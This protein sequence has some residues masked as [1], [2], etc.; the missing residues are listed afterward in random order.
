[1][2]EKESIETENDDVHPF[3]LKHQSLVRP[4]LR[5]ITLGNWMF[6]A[7]ADL[8]RNVPTSAVV[9]AR[10]ANRINRFV[11]PEMFTKTMEEV[12][13][14][15]PSSVHIPSMPQTPCAAFFSYNTS[16]AKSPVYQ[17]GSQV[18]GEK[19][20]CEGGCREGIL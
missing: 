5:P 13:P 20:S 4:V 2:W 9:A 14:C 11:P 7:V 3:N 12:W 17:S 10:E 19:Q 18:R 1:V 16:P 15:R 8:T 6:E